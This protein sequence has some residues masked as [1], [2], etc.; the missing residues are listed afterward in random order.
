MMRALVLLHRWLGVSFCLLFAMWFLTG[1]VMHFVPFPSLTETERF[2]G[3]VPI[4]MSQLPHGP[5]EAV[6]RSAIGDATRVRLLQRSDG[7]VY[8]VTGASGVRAIHA[9]DLSAAS[10]TSETL[11]LSIAQA[12]ARSRGFDPSQAAVA[13]LADYDQWSVPNGF[14]RHR[15]LYRIALHDEHGTELYVSS[16]TGEIALDTTSHERAWNYVGS[17]THWIY[18][19]V[20]RKSQASWD[21]TVWWLSLIA[22]VAA[23]TGSVLGIIRMKI[24]RG[25]M[26]SPFRGWHWWH[27]ILGLACMTFVLTWIFSGW[28]SM[29]HGRLFSTGKL[30]AA[31][32]AAV[33]G[34]P[35]WQT[36]P[37]SEARPTSAQ[38]REV[39]WFVFDGKFYR[40]ER[41]GL[42]AQAL[43]SGDPG[44]GAFPPPHLFLNPQDVAAFVNRLAP[45]CN[46]PVPVA[47]DDNYAVTASLPS[48]PVYRSVCGDIWFHIDGASGALLERLDPSRR[49]YRWFYSALHTMDIPALTARPILRSALIVILCGCGLI[50][51]LTGVI[52]GWRRLR[53]QVSG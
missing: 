7:P 3:L 13:E 47:P 34:K 41:T 53:W 46:S 11:A 32:A 21:V 9:S 16:V 42:D 1:I 2:Y 36:L 44:M 8:L 24:M 49:A 15:P 38:A 12:A 33:A 43:F 23:I 22:L 50:F 52:I 30:T 40:R 27:H 51:S 14:D 26:V 10:V 5:A 31:E 18:P 19:T 29:D 48:A 37:A 28:L 4:E 17:V 45:S 6:Q 39:E 35:E 20:L 25:G